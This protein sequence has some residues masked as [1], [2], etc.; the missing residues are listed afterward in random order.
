MTIRRFSFRLDKQ[1]V[2]QSPV[3]TFT[4]KINNIT[5]DVALI[6]MFIT[7]NVVKSVVF[8]MYFVFYLLCL[9]IPSLKWFAICFMLMMFSKSWHPVSIFSLFNWLQVI[10]Q[11]VNYLLKLNTSA[12][13]LSFMMR[14]VWAPL[15]LLTSHLGS[16]GKTFHLELLLKWL[17]SCC[18]RNPRRVT[19]TGNNQNPNKQTIQ[20]DCQH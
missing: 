6:K 15:L 2:L 14:Q 12:I 3:C 5:I 8:S 17:H 19:K 16:G 13:V 7:S 4:N 1:V 18:S 11:R 20:G 9:F 10:F